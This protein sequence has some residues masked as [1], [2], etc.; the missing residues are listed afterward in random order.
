MF[1]TI[2]IIVVV[3]IIAVLIYAATKP[4]IFRV[5]RSTSIKAPPEKVFC[6]YE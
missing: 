4:D 1:K 6:N 2:T 3:L 5:Q